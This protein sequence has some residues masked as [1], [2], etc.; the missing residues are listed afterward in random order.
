MFPLSSGTTQY[1]TRGFMKQMKIIQ[2]QQQDILHRLQ[3]LEGY[4]FEQNLY[5]NQTMTALNI[6]PT[7]NTATKFP[8]Y[9]PTSHLTCGNMQVSTVTTTAPHQS[10]V[11]STGNTNVLSETNYRQ[12]S[13]DSTNFKS[14]KPAINLACKE[15]NPLPEIDYASLISPQE[16]VEKHPKLLKASKIPTLAVKLAREAYFGPSVMKHCTVRGTSGLHALPEKG[17]CDLKLFLK[18]LSLPRFVS[19]NIDFESIWKSCIESIG[20]ACKNYR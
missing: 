6:S 11:T 10:V 16:V 9:Y 7:G 13:I 2:L 15:N 3:L 4:H 20:Q 5:T 8:V 12:S 18:K 19:N 17:L 1:D 14:N